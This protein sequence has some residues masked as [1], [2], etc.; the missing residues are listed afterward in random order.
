MLIFWVFQLDFLKILPL[1]PL[2]TFLFSSRV[3]SLSED[4]LHHENPLLVKMS[5]GNKFL[6]GSSLVILVALIGIGTSEAYY[7]QVNPSLSDTLSTIN[8]TLWSLPLF[9]ITMGVVAYGSQ[10]LRIFGSSLFSVNARSHPDRKVVFF[11]KQQLF[12]V[13][14]SLLSSLPGSLLSK[15]GKAKTNK[16]SNNKTIKRPSSL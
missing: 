9:F 14:S 1:F 6:W 12:R 2:L 7:A 5:K 11:L 8:L 16:Q 3:R 15:Q 13:T 4:L 10:L